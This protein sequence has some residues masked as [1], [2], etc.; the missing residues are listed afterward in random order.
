MDT[1]LET[2]MVADL[3]CDST[4][5]PMWFKFRDKKTKNLSLN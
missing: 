3:G 2:I 1:G 4:D 5:G